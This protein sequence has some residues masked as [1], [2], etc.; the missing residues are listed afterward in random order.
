MRLLA[1]GLFLAFAA[2]TNNAADTALRCANCPEVQVV[3]IIDGDTLDTTRGR[4]RLFGVDTPEPGQF[5]AT[6]A[7]ERLR[8]LAGDVVRLED[9]PRLIGPYGRRLAYVYTHDG[10]SIDEVLIAEGLATAWGRATPG[11]PGRAG[12]GGTE[13]ACG[14]SVVSLLSNQ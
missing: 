4:V 14:V 8:A 6:E 10:A 5:C 12:A 11:L 9:G 1:L 7:T 3:R 2:C 13:A